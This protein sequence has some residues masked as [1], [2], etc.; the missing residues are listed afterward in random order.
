MHHE[1]R[2]NL[3]RGLLAPAVVITMLASAQSAAAEPSVAG[4]VERNATPLAHVDPAAPLDDLAPLRR[5]IGDARIVGLGES[6]HGAAEELKLKHRVT[7]L[8]VE[9]LGFRSLALE[10]QGTTGVEV[11]EY[12][13]TGTGDLNAI[14]SR[15]G[16]QWQTR[17]MADLLQWLAEFNT[18][19]AD[20]VQFTGVEY[21]FTGHLAYNAVDT[22]V[23]ATA[24]ERLAELRS[25]LEW[26]KPKPD[27]PIHKHVEWYQKIENKQPYIDH[28]RRVFELVGEITS[29]QDH[30]VA[31]NHARQILSFFEHYSLSENDAHVY[32]DAHAAQNLRWWRDFTG[33]KVVYWA[34]SPHTANAPGLRI[35]IPPKPDMVFP[36]AGSY[37]R[38]WYGRQYLSIGFTFDHGK[39]NVGGEEP[40]VMAPPKPGWFEQPLGKVRYDQFAI[41]LRK[42]APAPVRRWSNGPIET[43]GLP[44]FGPDS[45]MT[46]GSLGQWFDVLIHRQEVTPT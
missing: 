28:A 45:S 13:R 2:R 43:R 41:D 42:P 16:F 12:L 4:W 15:L 35:A 14:V 18:G 30:A 5:S 1:R 38:Q 25:H 36:S 8:L 34:A 3:L 24:P 32:R 40:A 11:N 17:E 23:A 39:V 20:K 6:V 10:D 31:V 29:G 44:N 22:Y 27:E 33:D 7:R 21:Y 19:R 26:I 9:Q 46:G 37:L